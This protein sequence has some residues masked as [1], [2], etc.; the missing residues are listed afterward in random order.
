M[1]S[2]PSLAA[3]QARPEELAAWIRAHWHIEALH[4]IRDVTNIIAQAKRRHA[5]D[6]T[7]CLLTL[8]PA[9]LGLA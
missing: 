6:S 9:T 5:Q 1:G 3:H 7:P 4:H 8:G 2:A